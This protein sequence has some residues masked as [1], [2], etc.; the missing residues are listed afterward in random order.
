MLAAAEYQA[1]LQGYRCSNIN[2]TAAAEYWNMAAA[3]YQG[4]QGQYKYEICCSEISSWAAGIFLQQ[5]RAR[6]IVLLQQNGGIWLQQN[7]R[8]C[9]HIAADILGQDNGCSKISG[10]AAGILL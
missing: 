3:E 1:G 8:G 7:I 10:W 5:Y 9:R 6:I 4:L 2:S